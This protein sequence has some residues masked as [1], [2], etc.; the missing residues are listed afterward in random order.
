M[1]EAREVINELLVEI[2]HRILAIENEGLRQQGV[3]LS[4][5]EVHVLEAISLVEEP[6]MT[7]IA[8]KIGITVGS[9]TTAINTLYQKKYVTRKYDPSDRRKV[10]I[11]LEPI[12]LEALQKHDDF[13]QRM[14]DAIFEDLHL[15]EDEVLIQSLKKV[16]GYFKK[17]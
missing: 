17:W 11:A 7:N 9:L 16:S 2:F 5:S 15:A 1:E 14:I 10:L 8:Q 13:H 12:A 3:S 6:S 4:M